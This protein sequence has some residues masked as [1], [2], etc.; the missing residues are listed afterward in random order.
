MFAESG[1][2]GKFIVNPASYPRM[3]SFI[4]LFKNREMVFKVKDTEQK[5]GNKGARVDDAGKGDIIKIVNFL[6]GNNAYTEENTTTILK[7]GL[8]V[9][10]EMLARQKMEKKADNKTWFL[11]PEQTVINKVTEYTKK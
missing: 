7:I 1:A 10:L 9:V 5:W 6:V 11:D 2:L 8:C 3:I 4:N